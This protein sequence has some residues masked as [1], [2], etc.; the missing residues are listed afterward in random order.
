M[1]IF[2]SYRRNDTKH[3]AGRLAERFY[4]TPGVREVFIDVD[5]IDPGSNFEDKIDEGLQQSDVCVVLIGDDWVGVSADGGPTRILGERDFVRQEAAKALAS[6][7]KVIP[8]LVDG[9]SMP[10]K[11]ALPSDL[12]SIVSIDAVF[13]RHTSFKQD[14]EILE[15]AIFSRKP[16]TPTA[17]FFNQHPFLTLFLK[18]VAGML[19]AIVAL[20]GVMAV[21]QGISGQALSEL[22]GEGLA[23]IIII[24]TPIAGG[25]LAGW[26]S[27]RR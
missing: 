12:H 13:L 7:T 11:D 16:R 1:K 18:V 8:V 20:V 23:W 9:A 21:F 6:D 4:E 3:I 24:G 14:A 15:D 5:G 27:L 26:L 10:A 22:V 19:A 2:L 17:R 25:V